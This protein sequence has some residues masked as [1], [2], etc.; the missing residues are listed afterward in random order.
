MWTLLVTLNTRS[1]FQL[2]SI[3]IGC[4]AN[5]ALEGEVKRADGKA[6]LAFDFSAESAAVQCIGGSLQ[7]VLHHSYQQNS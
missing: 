2:I 7:W 3:L 5:R 4:A 1:A 6:V